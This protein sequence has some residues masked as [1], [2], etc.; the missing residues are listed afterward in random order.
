MLATM[1]NGAG[2]VKKVTLVN[3]ITQWCLLVPG[4]YLMGPVFGF[5]LIG[6]WMLHQF[7]YR[8]GH[9]LIFGFFWRRGDWSK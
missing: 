6:I 4:A 1:L 5:G 9:V 7:G 8:A 2:D 3:L